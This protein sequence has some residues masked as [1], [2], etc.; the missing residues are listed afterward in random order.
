M[1]SNVSIKRDPADNIKIDK[2]NSQEKVDGMVSLVMAIGVEL[3]GDNKKTYN[4]HGLRT[5]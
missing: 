5:F 2:A 1:C 3:K 4:Q